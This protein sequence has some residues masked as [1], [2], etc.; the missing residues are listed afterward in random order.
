MKIGIFAL[1]VLNQFFGCGTIRSGTYSNP[2]L[3]ELNGIP[4]V[5]LHIIIIILFNRIILDH[6]W[7]LGYLIM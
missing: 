1:N 3:L 6:K 7:V 4:S 5:S 2:G